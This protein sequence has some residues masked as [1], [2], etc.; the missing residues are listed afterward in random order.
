ME[1]GEKAVGSLKIFD[2][3]EDSMEGAER[4]HRPSGSGTTPFG[5]GFLFS[6]NR[7]FHLRLTMWLSFGQRDFENTS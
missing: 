4:H 5:V 2:E 1:V 7:R 6:G 3:D